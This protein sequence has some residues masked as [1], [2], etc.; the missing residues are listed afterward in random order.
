MI[1]EKIYNA[2]TNEVQ[3]LEFQK[4]KVIRYTVSLSCI[5]SVMSIPFPCGK[6]AQEKKK[7]KKKIGAFL[8]Q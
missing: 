4:R 3:W 2:L 8:C 6:G 1:R 7:K 5:L